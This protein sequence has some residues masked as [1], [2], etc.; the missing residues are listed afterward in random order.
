[1]YIARISLSTMDKYTIAQFIP[2]LFSFFAAVYTKQMLVFST[3]FLGKLMSIFI[4]AFYST[5]NRIYGLLA[6]A[7]LVYFHH[8]AH[9]TNMLEG[10]GKDDFIQT[11]C[12]QGKL[13]YKGSLVN[14]EMAEHVFPE[15]KY[16]YSEHRCN[17]CDSACA[18]TILEDKIR[19]EDE[20]VR[21][22][23]TMN[24]YTNS[25]KETSILDYWS[26]SPIASIGVI[27]EP[28]SYI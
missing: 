5:I 7:I 18:Y 23:T 9:E 16:N 2:I 8:V 24:D 1:M 4:I 17:P 3:S 15:I 6:A 12:D 22:K 27:S 21:P 10:F 26:K 20:L 11:H 25:K 19:N 28:F 13:K 14:P